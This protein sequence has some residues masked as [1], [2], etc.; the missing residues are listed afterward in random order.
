MWININNL[1]GQLSSN[2]HSTV[3]HNAIK[4]QYKTDTIYSEPL[5]QNVR[6]DIDPGTATARPVANK[7]GWWG[8]P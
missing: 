1:K 3:S 5:K 7:K 4:S 2:K 6:Q 8:L